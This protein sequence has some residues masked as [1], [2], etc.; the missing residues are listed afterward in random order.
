MTARR[1]FLTVLAASALAAC[2][3]STPSAADL[4]K[5][6]AA[7]K[8]LTGYSDLSPSFGALYLGVI[9][10]DKNRAAALDAL[11]N[12]NDFKNGRVIVE[13]S[14]LSVATQILNSWYTGIYQAANGPV[15]G[16]WTQALAWKACRFTKPPSVCAA[17]GSWGE[18][19]VNPNG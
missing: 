18:P 5:F 15:T 14:A 3:R 13:P 11:Y 2:A 16:T 7:S 1:E 19:P 12:D 10:G 4:D 8:K 6:M 9:L 17:P